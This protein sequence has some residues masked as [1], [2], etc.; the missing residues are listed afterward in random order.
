MKTTNHNLQ[1]DYT[2]PPSAKDNFLRF[3]TTSFLR[4][5]DT[6]RSLKSA[7]NTTFHLYQIG[8]LAVKDIIRTIA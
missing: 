4:K 5:P 3:G 7:N 2:L 1:L 6:S 8:S